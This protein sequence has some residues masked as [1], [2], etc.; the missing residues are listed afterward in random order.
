MWSFDAESTC[1]SP[2]SDDSAES[3]L[4]FQRGLDANDQHSA[5]HD[6]P[7]Q[8][9]LDLIEAIQL[10]HEADAH[11]SGWQALPDPIMINISE[12][13]PFQPGANAQH[14]ARGAPR[15]RIILYF[16]SATPVR[17]EADVQHL[18]WQEMPDQIMVNIPEAIQRYLESNAHRSARQ[19]IPSLGIVDVPAATLQPHNPLQARLVLYCLDCLRSLQTTIALLQDACRF[20]PGFS[21]RY[22]V[23]TKIPWPSP[24]MLS[25][26]LESWAL[27]MYYQLP[28]PHP[29][30]VAPYSTELRFQ[31][32]DDPRCAA[33]ILSMVQAFAAPPPVDDS[34]RLILSLHPVLVSGP[35]RFVVP[36]PP[37]VDCPNPSVRNLSAHGLLQMVVDQ[38]LL[39]R[40]P[41]RRRL[42]PDISRDHSPSVSSTTSDSDMVNL[43]SLDFSHRI[44]FAKVVELFLQRTLH[45]L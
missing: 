13:S 22:T 3:R 24:P 39:H 4:A 8:S 40:R 10:L 21:A 36:P 5:L 14:S 12:A 44:L 32:L 26:P 18:A 45:S 30:Q 35:R 25:W 41:P 42:F 16:P 34:E 7:R 15:D 17:P 31:E 29:S 20:A 33:S 37:N 23:D 6:L 43:K 27:Q 1:S 11:H 9:N 2:S 28:F 19:E 38:A